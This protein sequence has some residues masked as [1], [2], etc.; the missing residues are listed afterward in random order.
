[1]SNDEENQRTERELREKYTPKVIAEMFGEQPEQPQE[2]EQPEPL[3]IEERKERILDKI[4]Q[5]LDEPTLNPIEEL[6]N[7]LLRAFIFLASSNGRIAQFR[8][9]VKVE[10]V[11][12][13]KIFYV[14]TI[15]F[16][17]KDDNEI[18]IGEIKTFETKKKE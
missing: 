7:D 18:E 14:R 1:M 3:T 15:R 17:D 10:K 9:D 13:G 4:E 2:P 16:F 12:L 8:L 11:E 5:K 6:S